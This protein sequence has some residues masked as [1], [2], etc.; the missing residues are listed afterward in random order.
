MGIPRTFYGKPL[1]VLFPLAQFVFNNG[2]VLL[3]QFE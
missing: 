2:Q 1:Q 3:G